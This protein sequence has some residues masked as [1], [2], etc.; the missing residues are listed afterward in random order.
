MEKEYNPYN[1][2]T[3][4]ENTNIKS[5][6]PSADDLKIRFKEGSIPLQTDY[7]DLINIADIGRKATGQAPGQTDNLDSALELDNGG[8]LKVKVNSSGGLEKDE[9]GLGVKIKDKSLLANNDGLKVNISHG[10]NVDKD[11]VSVLCWEGGGIT[12][13]DSTGL[14]L[15]LDGGTHDN[16]W[17]GV[18]GLSLSKNG[19]KVK[20]SSG[21]KV[22]EYGVS[23]DIEAV[24]SKLA[25]RIIPPGTIVPFYGSG[26]GNEPCPEGWAW[27]D[28]K[29]GTP[30]LN[31]NE[32]LNINL[33]SGN[34]N[35]SPHSHPYKISDDIESEGILVN[36]FNIRYMMKKFP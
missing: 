10:I 28:G 11:G 2:E 31:N 1:S 32:N 25:D 22:D 23:V 27:C 29:N 5:T 15:K 13:T 30:Y 19:V 21:I 18:S 8:M 12:V 20:A 33:I 9:Y 16:S 36:I 24:L 7:A 34:V 17:S 4:L 14:Y 35:T 6:G 3:N 26:S